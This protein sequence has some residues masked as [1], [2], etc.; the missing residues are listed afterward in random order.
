MTERPALDDF[1]PESLRR[2]GTAKWSHFE[3]D[4]L[5]AW[6]AEMDF[7]AAPEVRRA[8][9]DAAEREEY[10]YPSHATARELAEA[11]AAWQQEHHGWDVDPA[12]VHALSDVLKGLELGIERFSPTDSAVI[13]PTPSYP[14]FFEVARAA[15][16]PIVE[17][18]VVRHGGGVRQ[19]DL[20]A[21][22]AAF[23]AGAGT[24]VL[25]HPHNPLGRSFTVAELRAI[26]EIVDRHGGRVVADEVHAPLTYPGGR[27]VPY[28]TVS[29]A[30][31]GHTV[32]LTSASKAWNV[33]GLK[34]AQLI[35]SNP[36]DAARWQSVPFVKTH[37]TATVGLRAN[38]AAYR[39]GQ[40]WLEEVLAYL[41]GN[42]RLLGELLATHLPGVGYDVPEATYLA[43]LD[44]TALELGTEPAAFFLQQ[45]RV[46]TSA[47]V[48]FGPVGTD[49]LRFN[50]A[51]SRAILERAVEAMG[52]AVAGR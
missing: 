12:H 25:C 20:D 6:I 32:T 9:L 33:P 11:V 29:D 30:A 43:W 47:G 31:A 18:P 5:A 50:F 37:G 21:I 15:H 45:A 7:P 51:T 38:I 46:A 27:H 19:L 28:A 24:L 44:C 8:V 13:I 39:H 14:P 40:P 2:R 42:R 22:D 4:V 1:T 23:A 17:A 35:L 34:C 16:R 3:P 10:G 41:D 36:R 26:A 52:K 48:D 49:H